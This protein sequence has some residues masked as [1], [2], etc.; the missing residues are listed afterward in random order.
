MKH[1][2]FLIVL[3][4]LST[5]KSHSQNLVPN[6]SFEE[7]NYCPSW[8]TTYAR[9]FD[10][11]IV[12]W[13]VPFSHQGSSDYWHGCHRSYPNNN[14]GIQYAQHGQGYIGLA[15]YQTYYKDLREYA[16]VEL[17]SSLEKDVSYTLSMWVSL[18]DKCEVAVN[19]IGMALL[20]D[21]QMQNIPN[22][23]HGS[24][25]YSIPYALIAQQPVNDK[26]NWV[27]LKTEYISNGDEK[28]V[29]LGNLLSGAQTTEMDLV[30]WHNSPKLA[31]YY[32]D[33]ITVMKTSEYIVSNKEIEKK[34]FSV[35][36][37]PATDIINIESEDELVKSIEI[38]DVNG[39]LIPVN[40]INNQT[41]DIS[42]LASGTYF[43]KIKSDKGVEVH[44]V[45]KK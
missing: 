38:N 24:F 32:I 29:L 8:Y 6:H 40:S 25:V 7:Y 14:S 27:Q 39:R 15:A 42:S 13:Y 4:L 2:Y 33:N 16:M 31:Y 11:M 44:K 5:I 18:A 26:V 20:S 41:I 17:I 36:P 35:Y 45:V 1:H 22:Q 43:V 21:T 30:T 34:Y 10:Q 28:Y 19:G 9:Q 3:L 23:S 12:D 37:N